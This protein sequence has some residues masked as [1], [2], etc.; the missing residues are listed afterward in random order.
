[1]APLPQEKRYSYADLLSWDDNTRYE[2][3]DGR[4]VAL[5][6]PTDVHQRISMALSVQLGSYLMGKKCRVYAAPFDVRLFEEEGDSPE[7]VDTVVQPD[8]M[9]VCDQNKV[10]RHGVHGAPD[11]VIEILSPASARYDRL[12]KFNLY[13][14]AGVREYWL[15]DPST[16]TVSVHNLEDG[17]Y[18]AATVY[19]SELSVPVGVLDNCDVDLSAVFEQESGG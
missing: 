15:V 5:A 2:L 4:P 16:R 10:D 18:H 14:R 17:A 13:Q 19:S 3:Y 6:S 9:V 8:L 11:L 12:V 7:D 1:M